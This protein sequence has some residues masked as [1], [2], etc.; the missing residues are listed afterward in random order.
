MIKSYFKVGAALLCLPLLAGCV[1]DDYD[2]SDI[3]TTTR[4]TIND[5]TIP[6]NIDVVTLGDIIT[7]DEDSKIQP[8]TINGRE[9]YALRESGSF[10]SDAIEIDKVTAPAPTLSPTTAHL[11]RMPLPPVDIP[12]EVT[13]SYEIT[14]MGNGIVYNAGHVDDAIVDLEFIKAS[15]SLSIQ[16]ETLNIPG[17]VKRAVFTDVVIQLPKGLDADP[18]EGSYDPVSGLWSIARHEASGQSTRLIINA[19]GVD[20]KQAGASIRPDHTFYYEGDFRILQGAVTIVP[21]PTTISQL[22]ASLE[23]RASYSVSD[24]VA[25]SFTGMVNYKLDGLGIDPVSLS[26]IPD[27]LSGEGT[28]IRLANPQIYL[29]VNNPVADD[30]LDCSTGITLTAMRDGGHSLSFSPDNGAFTIGHNAADNKYNFVLAPDL[31]NLTT[32]DEYVAGLE[33]VEFSTLTDLLSTPE[34]YPVSGLPTSIGIRLDDPQ[35]PLSRVSDFAL[36]R[37]I[38]A[39]HGSYELIAP[40]ALEEGSLIIYTDTQDG[41]NDE[42]VD[43]ITVSKLSLTFTATN[44]TPI[45]AELYAWPIDVNGNRIKGVEIKSSTLPANSEDVPV[46]I[47]LTGEVKHLDGVV[48]EARVSG[49]K[50]SSSLTPAQSITL[51][52][53]RANVSGYYEK[54]F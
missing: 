30:N 22:P 46:T 23:F 4:I 18:E 49:S 41:W 19:S 50:D 37:Q 28:N 20:F 17:G 13:I 32:P 6:V 10:E 25:T 21:E 5:L 26:D 3:D 2:L 7:F 33:F 47:E 11:D 14:P 35:I 1:N 36:G 40:L 43:A 48:F 39:V 52:N 53:V 8:V 16:L 38:P 9:F 31:D 54:E 45:S 51:R 42:D 34:N 24:M 27:F 12:G 44:S 15:M 29:Q